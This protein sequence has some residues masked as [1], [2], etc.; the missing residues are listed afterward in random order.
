MSLY[1]HD[2]EVPVPD[3]RSSA[4][5]RRQSWFGLKRH[6]KRALSLPGLHLIMRTVAPRVPGVRVGRLPAPRRVRE[7]HGH[8]DGGEYVLV[9]PD[10]C[11][12]AKEMYWGQGRR[13]EAAD[14]F[15]LDVMVALGK[16]ARTFFDIGAYTGVFTMALTAANPVLRAHAFEIVPAVAQAL[17]RNIARNDVAA[18]TQVH[19]EGVG[20]PRMGMLVPAG[21]HG[22][23][24]PSF[25][26]SD[27]AFDD[28]VQVEFVALDDFTDQVADP[29]L[30]KIDVEGGEETL[31]RH[32]QRFLAAHAP[33]ILCE[34]LTEADGRELEA[35]LTPHGLGC[36][37]VG[38]EALHPRQHLRPSA[39]H[40][41]WLF[42]ARSPDELRALGV[43][44]AHG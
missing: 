2:L 30:I 27:M 17:A 34:V 3:F 40:R 14:A 8:V 24:L 43:P 5:A 32:G 35:L 12:I 4:R 22:S 9:G 10:R 38:A 19:T 6:I 41:D 1:P 44:V 7:V 36:Y 11:E 21:D 42:S 33:D 39:E 37:A 28:G 25:Y 13:P 26:S 15:A 29:V 18:R 31:L 20:D 23:A 16:H